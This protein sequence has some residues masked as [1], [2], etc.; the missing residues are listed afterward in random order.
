MIVEKFS[1]RE[2]K[3]KVKNALKN[4]TLILLILLI[5]QVFHYVIMKP[6]AVEVKKHYVFNDEDVYW[7]AKNVYF[8]ARNQDIDG[9]LAVV[10]VTLNRVEDSRW[11]DNIKS[12]VTQKNPRGCQFSWYCDSTSNIPKDTKT[13]HEIHEF[14]TMTLSSLHSIEDITRGA[15]F[16]HAT[17]VNPHWSKHM[18][19]VVKIGD[20]IF[21]K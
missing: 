19:R 13:F 2:R 17:Y 3:T 9:K 4:I 14:V 8:E 16:Y 1:L 7:L 6:N 20:H 21:Y 5:S 10:F 11:P 18:E 15:V 12:V